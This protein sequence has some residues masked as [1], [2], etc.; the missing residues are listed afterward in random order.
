M[1]KHDDEPVTA[2]CHGCARVVDVD[3]MGYCPTC[4]ARRADDPIIT[5]QGRA[6]HLSELER[7][8]AEGD[9]NLAA[10]MDGDTVQ[11]Q[12]KAARKA[13]KR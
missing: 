12:I 5:I 1:P 7:Q 13:K 2:A 11:E 10:A 8:A 4:A 3:E 6:L 9:E